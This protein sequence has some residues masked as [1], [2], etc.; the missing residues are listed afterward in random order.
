M[1]LSPSVFRRAKK[2]V[3]D[4]TS[5]AG[6]VVNPAKEFA[7]N[8]ANRAKQAAKNATGVDVGNSAKAFANKANKS[9]EQVG[10][11]L[12]NPAKKFANQVIG[13]SPIWQKFCGIPFKFQ[14]SQIWSYKQFY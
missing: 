10:S 9:V 13:L 1:S 12:P 3:K 2:A 4:K 5:K 11:D 14:R 7:A 8:N 6:A